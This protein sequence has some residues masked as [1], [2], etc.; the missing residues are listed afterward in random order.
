MSK[1]VGFLLVLF[2]LAALLRIDFFFTILYLFGA[3]YILSQLWARQMLKSL[4][5]SRDLPRRAFLG[6][7]VTVTLRFNNV[8]RLPIPWLAF[9]ESFPVI[10][11]TPPFFRQVITLGGK[12]E[13]KTQYTLS[14]R[15]RGYY[16]IGPLIAE[17]GDLLG[18]KRHLTGQI[19][20][21]SLIVYPKILPI[22]HLGLPTHSPQ[23]VLPTPLPLFQDPAR[24]TGVRSYRPGDNPRQLHWPA[25]AATGQLLVKQFQ[26]AIA[27]ENA[28]FLNLSRQDYAQRGYPEPAIELAITAAA[29][30]ANHMIVVE[31][32]PVGLFTTA[33][34]PLT[35]ARQ[36]FKLPPAKGRGRLMQILEILARVQDLPE[37]RPFLEAVRRA[38]VHLSWGTTITLITGHQSAELMQTLLWL[39]KSGFKVALALIDPPR[40][41]ATRAETWPNL[42]IAVYRIRL[43]KEVE[44]WSPLP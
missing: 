16:P 4:R 18:L 26:P 28:I 40:K 20:P 37:D 22:T 39:K 29:S 24:L 5:I 30:L 27:R 31:N 44:A 35:E 25:S 6:D 2:V 9:S 36:D 38:A 15:K 14:A 34:D 12:T 17:T 19:E 23:V 8:S 21:D 43:E 3:V 1:F 42:G 7:P 32:L 13:Y 11:S 33:M 41:R 10:L